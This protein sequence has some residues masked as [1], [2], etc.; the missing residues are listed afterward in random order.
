MRKFLVVASV[1]LLGSSFAHSEET[2]P[3]LFSCVD[4]KNYEID[5][6]CTSGLISD[7]KEFQLMQREIATKTLSQDI[8]V[9]ATTQFYPAKML[10]KVIAHKEQSEESEL[11]A[12]LN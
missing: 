4:I 9:I 3:S 7:S 2:K 10:I 12:L 6:Q 8:N 11:V 1:L 5:S